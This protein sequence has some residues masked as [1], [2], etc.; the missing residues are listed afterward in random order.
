MSDYGITRENLLFTLPSAIKE[1]PSTGALAN[2]QAQLLAN[3]KPETDIPRIFPT[4]DRQEEAVLDILAKDLKVDWYDYDYPIAVKRSLIRGSVF[5]HK[6]LGTVFA[7]KS[8]L[9]S[10]CPGSDV[11]EWFN[12]DGE[13]G[14]FRI[15]A[16]AAVIHMEDADRMVNAAS[17]VKRMSVWLD[18]FIWD[19]SGEPF[20]NVPDTLLSPRFTQSSAFTN[21]RGIIHPAFDGAVLFDG[22]ALFD[23]VAESLFHFPRLLIRGTLRG[24]SDRLIPVSFRQR[25]RLPEFPGAAARR[26]DGSA[27]FDGNARFDQQGGGVLWLPHFRVTGTAFSNRRG[28]VPHPFDGTALFDGESSFGVTASQFHFPRFRQRNGVG[29]PAWATLR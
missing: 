26:L 16:A 27:I 4:L 15:R 28:I 18:G 1:D 14:Y 17:I 24:A 10:L 3:R 8:A 11:V 9:N 13:P 25:F 2:A 12:Y 6:R 7:V 20:V 5:T 22:S 21:Y 29:V 23:T 19:Y